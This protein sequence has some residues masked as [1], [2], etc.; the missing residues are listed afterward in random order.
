MTT[1]TEFAPA[2]DV[3]SPDDLRR[4]LRAS[5]ELNSTMDLAVLLPNVLEVCLQA[6]HAEDGSLW[7]LTGQ[8]LKCGAAH[9]ENA[10]AMI[11][12]EL[13][14]SLAVMAG[15]L[16]N[17]GTPTSLM[18]ATDAPA[19]QEIE[20]IIG[21]SARAAIVTPLIARGE[22]LGVLLMVN[23]RGT[24][25]FE[26]DDLPFLEA[27]ADDAAATIRNARTFEA[28]R[29]AHDLRKL[30]DF[31]REVGSSLDRTRVCAT[32]V[33]LAGQVI[34]FDRCMVALWY[35]EKLRVH[36]VSGEAEVNR[37]SDA[38]REVERVLTSIAEHKAA[39]SIDDIDES[40]EVAA[41]MR[42]AFPDYV[43][44][45]NVRSLHCLPIRDG[46]GEIGWLLFEF[47]TPTQLEEW[48]REA[49][50]LI[51]AQSALALRNAELYANVPFIDWLEPLREKRRAL[52]AL[53]GPVW[54]A[55][56]GIVAVLAL[57]A[58]VIR[59]PLR[60]S[61]KEAVVRAAVQ[62]P[63]RAGVPGLV[64]AVFVS[65]GQ[66]VSAGQPIARL[67]NEALLTRLREAEAAVALTEREALAA[68]GRRDAGA[69]IA[70]RVKVAQWTETLA[71]LRREEARANIV[72]PAA[73][74]ILTPRLEEKVGG[75]LQSGESFAW[76]G[77]PASVE[78]ELRVPQQDVA[79]IA[80][81]DRVR[82]RVNALPAITFE[83]RVTG[84]A[85]RADTSAARLFTVRARLDN[86]EELLRPGMAI[87]ARVLTRTRPVAAIALRRPVRWLRM[88]LWW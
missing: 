49:L 25:A 21:S 15:S 77:E 33:N 72:S 9:G 60:V 11:G 3:L 54:L 38:M 4:L 1:R 2:L 82:A 18:P 70:A 39:V 58:S 35:D 50:E 68:Q 57:T 73:G 29:R 46:E 59:L 67:R 87:R 51:T 83:G 22:P 36:A 7:L 23:P 88:H 52:V 78:L 63:I 26:A 53:P 75:W 45:S 65:E 81:G 24:E 85:P 56:A 41:R 16:R 80:V 6:V 19:L 40:D 10:A 84:I 86:S 43:K 47:R 28:E 44:Q 76:V 74:V 27:L 14:A 8:T 20:A 71:L 79:Q 42:T 55:Y 62:E 48:S 34:P 17:G 61:A 32:I 64:E 37:K 69:A 31:S 13:P 30:L 5:H 12:R 66:R